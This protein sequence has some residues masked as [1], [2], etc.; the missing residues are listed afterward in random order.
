MV[1]VEEVVVLAGDPRAVV[2]ELE[3]GPLV[4][5][6]HV[7]DAVL[8]DVGGVVAH[9]GGELD[10]VLGLE[11]LEALR[12]GRDGAEH[13]GAVD[14]E[15]LLVEPE[16]AVQ[17]EVGVEL[18]QDPERYVGHDVAREHDV[19]AVEPLDDRLAEHAGVHALALGVAHHLPVAA[20]V[21][22]HVDRA[23]PRPE[24]RAGIVDGVAEDVEGLAEVEVDLGGGAEQLPEELHERAVAEL[25]RGLAEV[26]LAPRAAQMLLDEE[27]RLEHEVVAEHERDDDHLAVRS[28]VQHRALGLDAGP[29]QPELELALDLA[30][31]VAG[32]PGEERRVDAPLDG[33]A[34]EALEDL[35]VDGVALAPVD[36]VGAEAVDEVRHPARVEQVESR[37][38]GGVREAGEPVERVADEQ[39][40]EVGEVRREDDD[41]VVDQQPPHALDLAADDE[42]AP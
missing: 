20:E 34:A 7:V 21:V 42:P 18:A 33:E 6:R 19:V 4:V 26:L 10:A 12:N 37:P 38:E 39:A 41:V 40:V 9:G 22:G 25:A 24:A 35:E 30:G 5:E 14:G 17:V 29:E 11:L 36:A 2:D 13:Q 28:L 15:L 1:V 31:A 32:A 27:L 16:H 23:A 3:G 8:E